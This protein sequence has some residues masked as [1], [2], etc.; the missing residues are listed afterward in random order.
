MFKQLGNMAGI[1]RQAQEMGGKLQEIQEQ[2]KRQRVVGNSGGGMVEVEMTGAG[3]VVRVKLDPGLVAG[4]DIEMLE[5]LLPAAINQA[6]S[7]AR[8]CHAEAMKEITGGLS[9]PG[10][11]E[12][13]AKFSP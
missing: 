5:S 10:L 7:K 8:Q 13:L 6:Q 9:L 12:A 2:L 3:E 1:L 11:E 4:N